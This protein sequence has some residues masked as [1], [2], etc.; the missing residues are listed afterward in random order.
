[1]TQHKLPKWNERTL[2]ERI[3]TCLVVLFGILA[4]TAIILETVEVNIYNK[5]DSIFL[6][7]ELI[8][9]G[10]INWKHNKTLAIFLIVMCG[11][12]LILAII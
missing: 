5:L 12:F 3:F 7:L 2:L 8:C 10:V 11:I 6:Y 1:M 9:I 4:I